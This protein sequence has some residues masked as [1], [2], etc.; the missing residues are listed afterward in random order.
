MGQARHVRAVHSFICELLMVTMPELA[1]GNRYIRN[2]TEFCESIDL[3]IR[4]V[5][6]PDATE[7]DY[8]RVIL[9]AACTEMAP[10]CNLLKA[11]CSL[12]GLDKVAAEYLDGKRF[13]EMLLRKD[14]AK[15][16]KLVAIVRAREGKPIKVLMDVAAE[17]NDKAERYDEISPAAKRKATADM[18]KIIA[19]VDEIRSS[20]DEHR[21]EIVARVDDVGGKVAAVG[22]KVDR[23][24]LRGERKS[25]YGDNARNTCLMYWEMAQE[26]AEVRHAINTRVTY[27][28]VFTYFKGKLVAAGINTVKKFKAVLHATKNL[29]Y[30][31]RVKA[32]EAKREAER[33]A[34]K[35][36][37]H[38]SPL[39]PS[40][41]STRST[42]P[43][44]TPAPNSSPLTT[45]KQNVV[46]SMA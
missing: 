20:M 24:R 12:A 31:R 23:L 2:S 16:E 39:T 3:A 45:K 44:D 38:P 15:L 30:A 25:K 46:K 32:L 9:D 33:K 27:E 22:K 29:E 21:D 43:N 14:S 18:K 26:N 6:T 19:K 8:I 4:E 13:R 11:A 34:K 1:K 35:N 36:N 7:G 10:L 28:S 41:R 17:L 40:T 42:R 5:S 37:P